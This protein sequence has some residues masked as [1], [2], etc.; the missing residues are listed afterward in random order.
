MRCL[1]R[2]NIETDV[3]GGTQLIDGAEGAHRTLADDTHPIAESLNEFEL[4]AREYD[5]NT[6]RCLLFEHLAHHVDRDGIESGEGFVEDKDVRVVDQRGCQLHP[7]LVAQ[8][9][10]VHVVVD[11]LGDTEIVHPVST[12]SSASRRDKPV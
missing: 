5:R 4:V 10:V 12:W 9:Q 8:A 3:A 1:W 6:L 11:A 7:L 2:N